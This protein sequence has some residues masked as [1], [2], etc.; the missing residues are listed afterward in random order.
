MGATAVYSVLYT[1]MAHDSLR[2]RDLWS[3]VL[4]RIHLDRTSPTALTAR[5]LRL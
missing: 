1:K 2:G 3:D 5:L 4:I